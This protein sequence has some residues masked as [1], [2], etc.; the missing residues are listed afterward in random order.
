MEKLMK[1]DKIDA[2][3]S[4]TELKFLA[5]LKLA[6]NFNEVSDEVSLWM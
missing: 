1:A 3:D 6:C 2:K 5:Q 4:I